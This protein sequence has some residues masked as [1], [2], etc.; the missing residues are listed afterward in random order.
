M[1][2]PAL[3]GSLFVFI[4]ERAKTTFSVVVLKELISHFVYYISKSAVHSS[5]I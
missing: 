1:L 2:A 4:L 3:A 5:D